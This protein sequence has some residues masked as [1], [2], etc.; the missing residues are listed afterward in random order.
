LIFTREKGDLMDENRK[1]MRFDILLE[2]I[3]KTKGALKKLKVNNFSREGVGFFADEDL[4]RGEEVEIEFS[5][6]GDNVPVIAT[7]QVAWAEAVANEKSEDAIPVFHG[8]VK[9]TEI[10]N[11]D[12]GKILNF[13]YKKWMTA[14]SSE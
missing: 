9:L 5:I 3:C 7:G 1:Y 13:I 2:A 14:D 6:P 10:R 4:N 8:G 11:A 12:R